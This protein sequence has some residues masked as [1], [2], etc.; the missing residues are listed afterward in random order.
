MNTKEFFKEAIIQKL[1]N[2]YKGVTR[3]ANI[4]NMYSKDFTVSQTIFI[5]ALNELE[6][7]GKI[8]VSQNRN[9]IELPNRR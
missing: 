1:E 5:E 8:I 4:Y 2:E 6:T 7:E 9:F 3:Y